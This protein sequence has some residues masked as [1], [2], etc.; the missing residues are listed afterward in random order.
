MGEG[1]I[2]RP[3]DCEE[4]TGD[5]SAG[6]NM[7]VTSDLSSGGGEAKEG[8][9][10]GG[11]CSIGPPANVEAGSGL[12]N[13]NAH[14]RQAQVQHQQGANSILTSN[15]STSRVRNQ[16]PSTSNHS[17]S[18]IHTTSSTTFQQQHRIVQLNL[19]SECSSEQSKGVS[20][21]RPI[22]NQNQAPHPNT[23]IKSNSNISTATKR[24]ITPS[25]GG[26][27]FLPGM[28]RVHFIQRCSSIMFGTVPRTLLQ[29]RSNNFHLHS[30]AQ[31][32]Q[33]PSLHSV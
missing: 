30:A 4:G 8:V 16:N 6:A 5:V 19:P 20:G 32:N 25:M 15:T 3:I 27:H 22:Q 31:L 2:G 14:A 9:G 28:V 10:A 12:S 17:T 23:V 7:I 21:S 13:T 1:D 26:F 24:P 11:R 18:H 29:L 33:V